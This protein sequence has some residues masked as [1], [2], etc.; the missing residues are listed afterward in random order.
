M[1]II[2]IKVRYEVLYE[3]MRVTYSVACYLGVAALTFPIV[4]S[5]R[6][7]SS[8]SSS[9]CYGQISFSRSHLPVYGQLW[10]RPAPDVRSGPGSGSEPGPGLAN[11]TG[12]CDVALP[13]Q[14]LVRNRSLG[15]CHVNM[16]GD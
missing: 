1:S 9:D 8:R 11:T 10:I 5:K 6:A 13:L 7:L 14:L 12:V 15:V 16:T 3:A 4:G 2:H